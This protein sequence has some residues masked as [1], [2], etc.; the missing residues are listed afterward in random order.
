[1]KI[2]TECVSINCMNGSKEIVSGSGILCSRTFSG[3][4]CREVVGGRGTVR[5]AQSRLVG[6]AGRPSDQYNPRVVRVTSGRIHR[7]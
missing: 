2:G 6:D 7:Y 1:M 5:E 4:Q 3:I